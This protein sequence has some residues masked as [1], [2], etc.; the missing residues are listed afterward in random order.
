MKQFS[1]HHGIN[2]TI[3]CIMMLINSDAYTMPGDH[4]S[5]ME[6]TK[7]NIHKPT[8]NCN[9]R[10]IK[11]V[12]RMQK[13]TKQNRLQTYQ[14]LFELTHHSN[15][16][17]SIVRNYDLLQASRYCMWVCVVGILFS[18]SYIYIY[19]V[20]QTNVCLIPLVMVHLSTC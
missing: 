3:L 20:Q 17:R 6:A 16:A 8:Q 5:R 11:Y 1:F 2:C 18:T 15:H 4:H 19:D 10:E 13:E 14:S 12:L 9:Q 7:C